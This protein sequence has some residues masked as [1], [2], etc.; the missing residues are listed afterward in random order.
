MGLRDRATA[1]TGEP[2]LVWITCRQHA[3]ETQALVHGREGKFK[4][5]VSG[6]EFQHSVLLAKVARSAGFGC[7]LCWE[8]GRYLI[9]PACCNRSIP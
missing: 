9:R 8:S 2:A 5:G 6:V 7:V 3:A 4:E 1:P